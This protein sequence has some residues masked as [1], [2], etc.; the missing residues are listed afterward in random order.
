[1][2]NQQWPTRHRPMATPK[3]LDILPTPQHS[4]NTADMFFLVCFEEEKIDY[5]SGCCHDQT[6]NLTQILHR[7]FFLFF[8][9]YLLN[10]HVNY[11]KLTFATKQH[12]FK[13][14]I[15]KNH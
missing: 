15:L 8:I 4:K 6:L 9:F 5:L 12:K 14:H 2:N 7:Q 11:D 10:K 13:I 1:M 3:C